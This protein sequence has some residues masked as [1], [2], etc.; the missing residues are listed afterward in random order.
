MS[1]KS[2]A[3]RKDKRKEQKAQR[4]AAKKALYASYAA[5]GAAKVVRK[6]GKRTESKGKHRHLDANCG[7]PG[8]E[9]CHS[10][11]GD[12]ML[13]NGWL[14]SAWRKHLK[15]IGGKMLPKQKQAQ[16]A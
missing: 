5:K 9:R 10:A 11:T 12:S 1:K 16:A 3:K 2:K 6:H 4:K 15:E 14:R 13:A 8:C 7:N